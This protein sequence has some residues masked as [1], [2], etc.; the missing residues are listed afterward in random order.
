[1]ATEIPTTE[2]LIDAVIDRE[3]GYS[4][5]PA[6]RG[7]PTRFGITESVARENGYPG[8]M[9]NF[10]RA[11]A[12]SIYRRLYWQR[13]ALDKVAARYPA[14]AAELFDVAVNMGVRAAAGFLQRSLNA[15]NRGGSDYADIALDSSIGPAT[16]RA[17]DGFARV[18]GADGEAVLLYAIRSLRGTRYIEISEG[19]PANEAFTYGWFGRMVEMVKARFK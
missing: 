13:P 12:V 7:G 6:D 11:E 16:L 18:R 3:G 15:L 4:N 2:Q 5:H 17:L 8:D 9:R 14:V 19:R 1:M 10:P